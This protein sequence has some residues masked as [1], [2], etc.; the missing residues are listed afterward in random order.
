[1]WM[2]AS[3][4]STLFGHVLGKI[5]T[6]YCAVNHQGSRWAGIFVER[7]GKKK[8]RRTEM[9]HTHT[10]L[11]AMGNFGS[12][13]KR[14]WVPPSSTDSWPWSSLANFSRSEGEALLNRA[15]CSTSPFTVCP[16]DVS[17]SG[18]MDSLALRYSKALRKWSLESAECPS[19][20]PLSCHSPKLKAMNSAAELVFCQTTYQ[21]LSS[22][23][24]CE[25]V[26]DLWWDM[27]KRRVIEKSWSKITQSVL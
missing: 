24:A 27:V 2:N 4:S 17:F 14:W 23:D 9:T 22:I 3:W 7:P 20:K 12:G 19:C 6:E 13:G 8:L 5:D 1:M 21:Y 10:H 25:P 26:D 15:A 11:Q 16:G 18:M